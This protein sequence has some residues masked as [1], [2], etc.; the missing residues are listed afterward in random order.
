MINRSSTGQVFDD[1]CG[2]YDRLCSLRSSFHG[3]V[4]KNGVEVK[5]QRNA[6]SI[7]EPPTGHEEDDEYEFD[8]SSSGSDVNEF[9]TPN[10]FSKL[11]NPKVR[12]ASWLPEIY[13]ASLKIESR[14]PFVKRMLWYSKWLISMWI[15]VTMYIMELLFTLLYCRSIFPWEQSLGRDLG[16]SND[17]VTHNKPNASSYLHLEILIRLIIFCSWYAFKLLLYHL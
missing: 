17:G 14:L 3:Q 13:S 1:G 4:L 16:S 2:N 7:L 11:N 9:S 10:E 8:I 6:L 15:S 12:Y 5:L